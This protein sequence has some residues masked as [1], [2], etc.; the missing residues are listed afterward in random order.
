MS[1]SIYDSFEDIPDGR[2]LVVG[3][4]SNMV[5]K[6]VKTSYDRTQARIP[7]ETSVSSWLPGSD[8]TFRIRGSVGQAYSWADSFIEIEFRVT[9][10]PS[11]ADPATDFTIKTQLA[12]TYIVNPYLACGTV[13]RAELQING[14]TIEAVEHANQCMYTKLAWVSKDSLR[15]N[16]SDVVA[17][18]LGLAPHGEI[19][20]AAIP[21]ANYNLQDL[22]GRV[23]LDI[24]GVINEPS[25]FVTNADRDV[26]RATTYTRIKQQWGKIPLSETVSSSARIPLNLLFGFCG[27]HQLFTSASDEVLIRLTRSELAEMIHTLVYNESTGAEFPITATSTSQSTALF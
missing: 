20:T 10:V 6:S 25:S 14:I 22:Q 12:D 15:S 1:E 21:E 19:A 7:P 5:N 13:S 17:P 3:G 4:T 23:G 24:S 2:L 8:M 9:G 11:D 26:P 18:W 27:T 16:L